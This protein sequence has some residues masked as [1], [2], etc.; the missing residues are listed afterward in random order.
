MS[1]VIDLSSSTYLFC[2]FFNLIEKHVESKGG[3]LGFEQ[4]LETFEKSDAKDRNRQKEKRRRKVF[5]R[6]TTFLSGDLS[7]LFERLLFGYWCVAF[8]CLEFQR[9]LTART[10]KI[11]CTSKT[12]YLQGSSKKTPCWNFI[13]QRLV[14]SI[15]KA[16]RANPCRR[17]H[18]F[19][20][21]PQLITIM[22]VRRN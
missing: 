8:K 4:Q 19:L 15:V 7:R 16:N 1:P 13:L 3:P 5:S 9:E 17:F 11:P 20:L 2:L 12:F 14:L 18:L 6:R 22:Q 21:G 10:L